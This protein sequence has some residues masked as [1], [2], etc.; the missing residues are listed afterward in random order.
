M[1][2]KPRSIQLFTNRCYSTSPIEAFMR[3]FKETSIP[4]DKL[5]ISFSRSSGPGGQNVNKVNTKVDLRFEPSDADWLPLKFDLGLRLI[6]RT[7][8]KNLSD[9]VSKLHEMIMKAAEAEVPRE[10][11]EETLARIKEL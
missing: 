6:Y 5:E 7:Q 2:F 1:F 3:N 9:C 11:S 10:P 8:P 4:V